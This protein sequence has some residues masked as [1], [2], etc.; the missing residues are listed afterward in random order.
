MRWNVV[1]GGQLFSKSFLGYTSYKVQMATREGLLSAIV[2]MLLPVCDLPGVGETPAAMA[3]GKGSRSLRRLPCRNRS[4][5]RWS[6]RSATSQAAW[7][8]SRS[9]L[10]VSAP[11]PQPVSAPETPL[12]HPLAG[13]AAALPVAGRAL[14]GLAGAYLLRALTESGTMPAKAGIAT[15]IA[16]ALLW[17]VWAARSP[18][19]ERLRTALDS[20][21]AVLVLCPLLWEATVRFRAI[22]TWMAAAILLVFAIFGMAISWR[23]SLLIVSTFATLAGLGTGRGAAGWPLTTSCHSRSCFSPSP[24]P[25][26]LRLPGTLVER[27]LAGGHHRG[28]FGSAGHLAGDECTRPAGRLRGDSASVAAHR[29]SGSAHHLSFQHDRPHAV[30]RLLV[31]RIRDGSMR[32]GLRRQSQRRP[33]DGAG[34]GRGHAGLRGRM[35]HRLIPSAG[36]AGRFQ[37]QLFHLFHVRDS[38]DAGGHANPAFQR[39]GGMGMVRPG[40]SSVS[41]WAVLSAG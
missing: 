8:R 26:R 5:R 40:D 37:P 30:P 36:T 22:D 27:A 14:L 2:L 10:G 6:A 12:N 17:L 29:A 32:R 39:S 41:G 31:H 4:W 9:A 38:A 34:D 13:M 20:L 11:R 28:S 7:L 1:I 3:G 25:S 21:T 24:R 15:G 33:A 23:K 35:L 18:V 16:Y 19:S